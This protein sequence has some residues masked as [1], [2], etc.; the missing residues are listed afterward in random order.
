[1][2]VHLEQISNPSAHVRERSKRCWVKTLNPQTYLVRPKSGGKA[3][4]IVTIGPPRNGRVA[5]DCYDKDTGEQC[6]ANRHRLLCAHANAAISR[7][8][9]NVKRE[10]NRKLKQQ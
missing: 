9:T 8:L 10:A 5:I 2:T 4:R 6:P 3:K 7:L 1:M